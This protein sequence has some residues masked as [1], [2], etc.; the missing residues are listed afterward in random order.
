MVQEVKVTN[1]PWTMGSW[2]GL[3]EAGA[4]FLSYMKWHSGLLAVLHGVCSWIYIIW[5]AFHY[6]WK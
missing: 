3:G 5:Y 1:L 4:F 6:G 2:L